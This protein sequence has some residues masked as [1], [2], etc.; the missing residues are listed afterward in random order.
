MKPLLLSKIVRLAGLSHTENWYPFLLE[1][2]FLSGTPQ[3]F[4]LLAQD[5]KHLVVVRQVQGHSKISLDSQL[6]LLKRL[7][8]ENSLPSNVMISSVR[9]QKLSWS[10][11][12]DDQHLYRLVIS[13]M[14]GCEMQSP[15]LGGTTIRS[16]HWPITLLR[17][18]R[19]QTL[20]SLW[21]SGFRF[22]RARVV[23]VVS[24]I[25]RL[26]KRLLPN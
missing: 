10:E 24:S 18:K 8:E 16:A 21:K 2:K 19:S 13:L 14:S 4:V 11:V 17:T 7:Q 25:V 12:C 26:A 1:V 22:I 23:S 3:R 9:L 15:G 5:L 20:V 6:I